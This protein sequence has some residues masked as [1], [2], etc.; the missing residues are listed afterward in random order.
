MSKI[1]LASGSSESI[2]FEAP[3]DRHPSLERDYIYTH[4][5]QQVKDK[6]YDANIHGIDWEG[7][8]K[9]Y[10]KFLPHIDNNTDFAIMLS[11]LLG[12]LN[13]SHTGARYYSGGAPMSTAS[14]GAY[15]DF[16]YDDDGVRIAEILPRGPLSDKSAGVSAGDIITAI[17]GVFRTISL[18]W[19]G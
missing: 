11:E 14:L 3:Y 2:E 5:W 9:N 18:C 1:N 16:S 4:A 7:Y 17:D 15:Y 19:Q 13:A 8:G 12:E 6:F 10:R